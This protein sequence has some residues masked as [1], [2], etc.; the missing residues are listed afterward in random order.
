MEFRMGDPVIPWTYYG[1]GEIVS[2]EERTL[3]GQTGMC[4]GVRVQGLTVWAPADGKVMSRLRPPTP[5]S[6]FKKLFA[7]L[8]GPGESL[9][10]DRFERTNLLSGAA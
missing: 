8:R 7:I 10:D 5:K 1:P 3:S 6:E 9:P 4:C 2:L